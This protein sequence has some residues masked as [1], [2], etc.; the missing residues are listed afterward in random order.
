MS[1]KLCVIGAGS[2][3]FTRRLFSDLMIVPEFHDIEVSFT[4]INPENLRMVYE[5]CQRDLEA[6]G[7]NI[8]IHTTR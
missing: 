4:D 7:V 3:G 6:N 8:K 2:V 5:L 1:F